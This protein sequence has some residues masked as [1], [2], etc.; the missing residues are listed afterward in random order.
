VSQKPKIERVRGLS[1]GDYTY[2]LPESRIAAYPLAGRDTSKLLVYKDKQIIDTRFSHIADELAPG[3]LMVFNNTRVV[4]ARL[5]F[6]KATGA[7]IEVFCLQPENPFYDVALALGAPS[8]VRWLCLVGNAKKW[9]SGPLTIASPDGTFVLQALKGEKQ[10]DGYLVDFS[11]KPANMSFAEVLEKVGKTPLPPYIIRPAEDKDKT[12]YQTIFA[13]E[14][15]SVA[16]PTAGLHFTDRVFSTLKKTDISVDYITLHV[17]AGTFKP[18]TAKTIGK[19]HMH[20]EQ[21]IIE[22]TFVDKLLKQ[23]APVVPV[24]TTCM[25]TLESIFWIGAKLARGHMPP[26][27]R[28]FLSQW[29][30]YEWKGALPDKKE[31]LSA[32]SEYIGKQGKDSLEGETA[33]IIVPG[34]DF[35]LTDALVTNFHQPGSTLLLLVAAFV[36]DRWKDMYAHALKKNY[37]FLSYGDACLLFRNNLD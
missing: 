15:G 28:V 7:R 1:A 14:D 5:E 20:A 21:F 18:V 33:L 13:R 2:D 35:A 10:A 16:A 19:H 23:D 36:G 12:T 22:K 17:G 27:D 34:Y 26:A 11:W 31:A 3:S 6:F 29:A 4:Q 32:L 8:P 30:P 24:G 37:R 25:R 9:K